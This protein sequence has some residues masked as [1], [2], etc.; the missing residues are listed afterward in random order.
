MSEE[1]LY[2]KKRQDDPGFRIGAVIFDLDGTLLDT[3]EIFFIILEEVFQEFRFP[4][5]SRELLVEAA[6]DGE[7]NW[8]M[9]LPEEIRTHKD[10]ILPK[11]WAVIDR[12]S[13]PLFRDRSTLIAGVEELLKALSG[14]GAK[15]GLVTS[16][17]MRQ[18]DVK[19]YPFRKSSTDHL[20]GAIVTADD[21]EKRKPAAEPLLECAG[22]LGVPPGECVYVGDMRVDI[23]AGKSAGMKTIGVLTGFDSCGILEA[24]NPDMI[25]DTVASLQ[26]KLGL[27]SAPS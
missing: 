7:F 23:R 10:E 25:L 5:V 19:L 26:E 11:V 8:D 24:E 18:L 27:E 16:T 15:I 1:M 13:P 3:K 14:A 9:V 6:A 17:D 2:L 20:L 21:V 4:M 12:I 22:R